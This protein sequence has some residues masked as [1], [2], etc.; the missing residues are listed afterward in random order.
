MPDL[1]PGADRQVI[2]KAVIC[3]LLMAA[4]ASAGPWPGARWPLGAATATIAPG[5]LGDRATETTLDY[6]K[7]M[8]HAAYLPPEAT[9]PRVYFSS[10]TEDAVCAAA[11][12]GVTGGFVAGNDNTGTGSKNAPY[13]SLGRMLQQTKLGHVIAVFDACDTWDTD[14]AVG[15]GGDGDLECKAGGAN[16]GTAYTVDTGAGGV[17]GMSWSNANDAVCAG[18]PESLCFAIIG[19][20][21]SG[22]Y[23]P[24]WKFETLTGT[25]PQSGWIT[26]T[27]PRSKGWIH[28]EN[29]IFGSATA[30]F[31]RDPGGTGGCESAS[32]SGDIIRNNDSGSVSMVHNKVFMCAT[33][34]AQ[35]EFWTAHWTAGTTPADVNYNW[36]M[37]NDIYYPDIAATDESV[38]AYLNAGQSSLGVIGDYIESTTVSGASGKTKLCVHLAGATVTA[39]DDNY[40]F[41]YGVECN[42]N[43]DGFTANTEIFG[44]NGSNDATT[45]TTMFIAKSFGYGA[46]FGFFRMNTGASVMKNMGFRGY[47]NSSLDNLG[48]VAFSGSML[49][50]SSFSMYDR[51]SAIWKGVTAGNDNALYRN[52]D[53]SSTC[54]GLTFD[55]DD[56]GAVESDATVFKIDNNNFG[57]TIAG[58]QGAWSTC[59]ATVPPADWHATVLP[60][61]ITADPFGGATDGYVTT[62]EALTACDAGSVTEDFKYGFYIPSYLAGKKLTGAVFDSSGDTGLPLGW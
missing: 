60:T 55:I 27:M 61:T 15:A 39:N 51:C 29:I 41:L 43:R 17:R 59:T 11:L 50:T 2:W 21:M 45:E 8:T 10:G 32:A 5:I 47:R 49:D 57:G 22:A 3:A 31:P 23:R 54:D 53:T 36:A 34:S 35:N 48:Y 46:K 26:S 33:S 16:C 4:A 19:S 52:T 38:M 20:D 62:A 9:Y 24:F 14:V 12:G 37:N 42:M 6:F 1:H 18:A 44:E 56:T 30:P 25:S 58:A 40:G 7:T 13:R 28:V